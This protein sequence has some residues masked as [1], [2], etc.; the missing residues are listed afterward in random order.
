[1]AVYLAS[2]AMTPADRFHDLEQGRLWLAA[3]RRIAAWMDRTDL[4][5]LPTLTG[6]R[7]APG[8]VAY[9]HAATPQSHQNVWK[10]A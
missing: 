6:P 2:P 5:H 3:G 9:S 10:T 1:V 8:N 4:E 7:T